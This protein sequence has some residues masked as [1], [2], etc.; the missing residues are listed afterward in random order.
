MI[1]SISGHRPDKL[2]NKETGYILPN[3]TYNY[4]CQQFEKNFKELNPSKII[5]GGALGA[6][7]YAA[8]VA[9]KLKIPY[10]VAVP[11]VGQE[12][13]WPESSQ[14]IYNKI[15]KNACEIVIVSEGG[16]AAYKMQTR[17]IWMIDNSNL[18]IGVHDGSPGGTKNCLDYA[19]EIKRKI[20]I[21]DPRLAT[22]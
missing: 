22:L 4:V 15:I 19:K 7:Q 8:F 18:T 1:I 20:I 2:P 21:I 9:Y 17:N 11:F 6:D 12:K 3:P 14:K 10:L 16:Y 13:A 5:T